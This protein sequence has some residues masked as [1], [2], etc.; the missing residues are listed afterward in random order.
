MRNRLIAYMVFF[1]LSGLQSW[2]AYSMRTNRVYSDNAF[3][4][5]CTQVFIFMS[6]YSLIFAKHSTGLKEAFIEMVLYF[7]ALLVMNALF[8][9]ITLTNNSYDNIQTMLPI[10]ILLG[11]IPAY[12]SGC[13]GYILVVLL[14]HLIP[15]TNQ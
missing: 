6:I 5:G 2:F 3:A 9:I 8:Y 4:I 12:I 15:R 13:S 1:L 14:K 11:F 10:A 7:V